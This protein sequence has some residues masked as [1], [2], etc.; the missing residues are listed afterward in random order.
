MRAAEYFSS[1][2]YGLTAMILKLFSI[3]PQFYRI[4]GNTLGK[5]RRI[6]TGITYHRWERAKL[7]LS[8]C[9]KHNAIKDGD[10]VIEIGTGWVHFESIVLRLFYDVKAT[11]FD[12]WDNRQ[13]EA[14]KQFS[15]Q[16]EKLIHK[17]MD[18]DEG[19]KHRINE[20]IEIISDTY[21]FDALYKSLGF[22]YMI[23]K[24]GTLERFQDKSF[25]MVYSCN[26]LE[27]V[28]QKVI[29]EVVKDFYRVLKP[30]GFS[31]H[32]IDLSDHLASFAGIHNIS[33]KNY[34]RFSDKEWKRFFENKVQYINRIQRPDWLGLFK[35]A[36]FELVEE[37]VRAC[38]IDRLKIAEMYSHLRKNNLECENMMVVHK[39]PA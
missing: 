32:K 16:L 26:V 1:V 25:Q 2:K 12:V 38:D 4:L 18:I 7:F 8:L 34:L 15:T 13:L 35:R 23:D 29:S 20:L 6:H 30:G 10:T 28:D 17:T 19:K 3:H 27:H 11:L 9:E 31:I 39:K 36:G 21:S 24:S 37:H 22:E 5:R 33:K 14:L